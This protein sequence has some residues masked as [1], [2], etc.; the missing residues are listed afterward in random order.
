MGVPPVRPGLGSG[1]ISRRDD[2][3]D[4]MPRFQALGSRFSAHSLIP[5]THPLPSVQQINRSTSL[6]AR[7]RT[8]SP[9]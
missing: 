2:V 8:V 1:F 4:P 3:P 9:T 5:K 7:P 6:N